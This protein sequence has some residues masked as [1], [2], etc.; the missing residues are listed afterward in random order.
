MA[1]YRRLKRGEQFFT[2]IFGVIGTGKSTLAKRMAFDD[3]KQRRPVIVYTPKPKDVWPAMWVT[4]NPDE[5]REAWN[6]KRN[7][8]VTWYLDELARLI[9]ENRWVE[10]MFQEGRGDP[11]WARLVGITPTYRTIDPTVREQFKVIYCMRQGFRSAEALAEEKAD[12]M[13]KRATT[14]GV[15]EYIALEGISQ[16]ERRTFDL[17]AYIAANPRFERFDVG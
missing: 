14:L 4:S 5:L 10:S 2:G 7:W 12:P 17:K 13:F 11:H 15:G 8:G 9:K 16:A 1:A 6:D 3:C